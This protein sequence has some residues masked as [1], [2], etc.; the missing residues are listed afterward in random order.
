[1]MRSVLGSSV[2]RRT[3]Y[4]KTKT[5]LEQ[6]KKKKNNK[7]IRNACNYQQLANKVLLFNKYEQFM[8]NWC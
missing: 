7:S 8:G 4:P 6:N 1:M 3:I 5:Q 2:L